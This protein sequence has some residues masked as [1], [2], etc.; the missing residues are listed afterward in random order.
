MNKTFLHGTFY[1]QHRM[2]T[3]F[4][5]KL[6]T[7]RNFVNG[8]LMFKIF[9]H[10]LYKSRHVCVHRRLLLTVNFIRI[11]CCCSFAVELRAFR[12]LLQGPFVK[13]ISELFAESGV[14]AS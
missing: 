11:L 14:G 8:K 2:L 6:S 10:L 13:L 4:L 3:F 1:I 12:S 5:R 9:T 7:K